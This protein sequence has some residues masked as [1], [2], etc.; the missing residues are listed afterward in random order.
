ML[1]FVNFVERAQVFRYQFDRHCEREQDLSSCRLDPLESI[2][3]YAGAMAPNLSLMY[4]IQTAE[5]F[6]CAEYFQGD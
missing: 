1:P 3:A 2:L 6:P 5:K 4:T